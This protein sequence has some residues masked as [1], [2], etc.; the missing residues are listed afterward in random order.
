MPDLSPQDIAYLKSMGYQD[1]DIQG[2]QVNVPQ[3]QQQQ[4]QGMSATQAALATLKAHA[5]GTV[6]GGAGAL[7][8]GALAAPW[9]AGPEAG[10]PADIAMLL[11]GAGGAAGGGYLG[12]KAQGAL[13]SQQTTD[14]QQQALQE[15]QAQHP[16]VSEGT[17]I[18][19]G[20]LASGGS[21]SPTTA[22][23]ALRQLVGRGVEG[24]S[25]ALKNVALQSAINP[26]LSTGIQYATSGQLLSGSDLLEQSV[27]GALFAKP[28]FLGSIGHRSST[29]AEQAEPTTEQKS[30]ESAKPEQEASSPWKEI[31]DDG[32]YKLSDAG[33]RS[34]FLQ[35]NPM[36]S[37]KGLIGVDRAAAITK[38]N[39][40]R[41]MPTDTMRDQLHSQVL[42]ESAQE[43]E[44]TEPTAE[45]KTLG[46][47]MP[48][49]QN[50]MQGEPAEP[51]QQQPNQRF[52]DWQKA[53]SELAEQQKAE[54]PGKP[55]TANQARIINP[56]TLLQSNI[57]R[58]EQIATGE[59]KQLEQEGGRTA[60]EELQDKMEG[61]GA[62]YA[63][64]QDKPKYIGTQEVPGKEGIHLYNLQHP[65]V[66]STGKVLHSVGSTVSSGTLDR[67]S[68]QYDKPTNIV[69]SPA[70]AQPY[71]HDF[72]ATPAAL[73][74]HIQSGKATTG[75]VLQH[76]ANTPGHPMQQLASTLLK[77][78]DKTGL[79]SRMVSS[80]L[81]DNR[82]GYYPKFNT[83]I[84]SPHDLNNGRV[85]MEEAVHSLTSNKLPQEFN[86][87]QGEDL[88]K[89]YNDY[90]K[91][92]SN[93]AVKEL[94]NAHLAVAKAQ[95]QHDLWFGKEGIA[96]KPDE[97]QQKFGSN[98]GYAMGN[99][100]EFIA[101]AFKDPTFQRILNRMPSDLPN[102]SVWQRIKDAVGKLLGVPVKQQSMLERV[103]E[104]S[105]DLIAQE[106]PNEKNPNDGQGNAN[107]KTE[108]VNAPKATGKDESDGRERRVSATAPKEE[109]APVKRLR[110][111]QS[112]VD[113][114]GEIPHLGAKE[115]AKGAKL[116]LN[117]QH[118]LQGRFKNPIIEKGRGLT[119]GDKKW[120]NEVI[121]RE[122]STRK[123]QPEM[124][125]RLSPKAQEFYAQ[126]KK[127]MDET[128]Q[129]SIKNR[130]PVVENGTP[131]L[132]KQDPSHWPGM[133]N[134]KMEEM[135]RKN[136]DQEG[137]QKAEVV[138]DKWNRSLGM[139]KEQSSQRID[140]W[141]QSI[142]GN[143][144]NQDISH[145]D[146]FNAIRKAQGSPL[147]PEFRE[148]NPVKA[149][150]R[151]A[152]RFSIAASHYKNIEANP[153]IMAALGHSKDAWGRTFAADPQGSIANNPTVKTALGQFKGEMSG[154]AEH[155]E[156][157]IS[158]IATSGLIAAPPLEVHKLISNQVK[159]ISFSS[160]PYQMARMIAHSITNIKEGYQH[161]KENGVIKLTASSV[162]DMFN[163]SLTS[164]E[165]L[166][167][168]AK[169]IRDISTLGGLT[170]KLNAGL[171]Q[172]QMEYI[173]PSKIARA[174][175]GD[176]TSQ[177]FIK[178][179]DPSYTRNKTYTQD[180][181]QKLA[182]VAASYIHGTG[183]IR[184][185]PAWMMNDGEVSGFFKLAHW[186][187]AQT[188]NFMKDVYTPATR[189]DIVP[190][191][192]SMFG[193]LAGGY[194]IKELRQ[195]ISG[196]KSPIPSLSEIAA[197]DK[198]LE[199]N[200]SLLAYN[201]IAA[202]Q[203]SG[204]GGLLSQVAKYPFDF[205]YK[206]T[207]QGATFPLDELAGDLMD[208]IKNVSSTIA[209]DPNLNWIDLASE[210][211]RHVLSNNIQLS[212]IA[213]NQG[214]NS[215]L[216]T[217][218]PAEKKQLSDSM[219]Q[220]R[221]FDIVEGLPYN[222]IDSASNPYNNL[223]QKKFKS[224]QDIGEAVKQLPE[225]ISG[226]M[227]AYSSHPDIMMQKLKALKENQFATMPSME[228]AP[229][230]FMKYLGY[231]QREKGPEEA[232]AELKDYLSHKVVNETK[233][234]LVP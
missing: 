223:E 128:G 22:G 107:A 119:E 27:G 124:V 132:L 121:N 33:V 71:P 115:L 70:S 53:Q 15:A 76:L 80:V 227:T 79:G 67:N 224:T 200:K 215:G 113:K 154:A 43:S 233:A 177:Q 135:F 103:L 87:L 203:Y 13:Q 226:I 220:L 153:R 167:G 34:A 35:A 74:Q 160:N 96:G 194:I 174:K 133:A 23:K 185:M 178:N 129:F 95:G 125:A 166:L 214:I 59:G 69:K 51:T 228:D 146:Y 189:G 91:N 172:S 145:Q 138:F 101:Q 179:L 21:F 4:P 44:T 123:L 78:G 68:V 117:E 148:Q 176:V 30:D 127:M 75:S 8:I 137:I 49:Q 149:M 134:Q 198:G 73:M 1:A 181:Q 77:L 155:N 151:Y 56:S 114:V 225:L 195:D 84:L 162:G 173:V 90:L 140:N 144:G 106:R 111:T 171:L 104:H 130:I 5:G 6:G 72:V 139:T 199:G 97:A 205:A 143:S 55:I 196:K 12:Q 229:I 3:A 211:T 169:G 202:M 156:A 141:K 164:A 231:L 45:N 11:L 58:I 218:M 210:V 86:G 92:G 158:S 39:A 221:R 42:A 57:G 168:L 63:P 100:H 19:S 232:Q 61:N 110:L 25:A 163:G 24:D 217:G 20:A 183:D 204:F 142:Q 48:E 10:L 187:V 40:L 36:Q 98:Y 206:N 99:L 170:T 213:I 193:S 64:Q 14:A 147:P 18:A 120:L 159:S 212:R 219:A 31:G 26:A 109:I 46:S 94:I 161:A 16:I 65:I 188:N 209:N 230:E 28:S 7:G 136:E 47:E 165:R 93:E 85:L 222:D 207:P 150:A 208:A 112:V 62:V 192:T 216:I 32:N 83:T 38:N 17:D 180:E 197:S 29:P 118:E 81:G 37:L 108:T 9:L 122:L 157:A 131:R 116:A 184:S 50:D 234:S 88:Y 52:L 54:V 190:L 41:Y 152:D 66:D 82:S 105:T 102:K 186:S 89:K 175:A 126:S 182:S 60:E 2:A 191:I 201:A